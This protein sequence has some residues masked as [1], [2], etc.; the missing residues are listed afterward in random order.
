MDIDN[1]QNSGNR[2]YL[3]TTTLL[4]SYKNHTHGK[5]KTTEDA[6]IVIMRSVLS[7]IKELHESYNRSL[8]RIIN[9]RECA[10]TSHEAVLDDDEEDLPPLIYLLIFS[11]GGV[12]YNYSKTQLKDNPRF[13]PVNHVGG[14]MSYEFREEIF[15]LLGGVRNN[16]VVRRTSKIVYIHPPSESARRVMF[17]RALKEALVSP[18]YKSAIDIMESS[19]TII[20]NAI[21]KLYLIDSTTSDAQKRIMF[22]KQVLLSPMSSFGLLLAHTH[23]KINNNNVE[24]GDASFPPP[25]SA[26][27]R[28]DKLVSLLAKNSRYASEDTITART[29]TLLYK[30]IWAIIPA[31]GELA[32]IASILVNNASLASASDITDNVNIIV[33]RLNNIPDLEVFI[34]S[35]SVV[36]QERL[37]PQATNNGGGSNGWNTYRPRALE[38]YVFDTE[39]EFKKQTEI[40]MTLESMLSKKVMIDADYDEYIKDKLIE[41]SKKR[42]RED[43]SKDFMYSDPNKKQKTCSDPLITEEG[44]GNTHFNFQ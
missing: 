31:L 20:K 16:N 19:L 33:E 7:S 42:L 26:E 37:N 43:L 25:L 34:S 40:C 28:I 13:T 27:K 35:I 8:R 6:L 18:T 41:Q 32:E 10:A 17:M 3:D 44:K 11:S 9:L 30:Y 23:H 12:A 36:I 4:D 1:N 29:I 5:L 2:R 21:N 38:S 15:Q 14:Q 22:N 39:N 24:G